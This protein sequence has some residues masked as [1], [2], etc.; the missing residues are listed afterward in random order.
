M[1]SPIVQGVIGGLAAGAATGLG[2]VMVYSLRRLSARGHDLLLSVA[3]GIMLAA[4]FYALLDPA[5]AV[6]RTRAASPWSAAA[7]VC[8]GVA[9]GVV[10]LWVL[11]R[12]VPHE[13]F[14]QGR[15]GPEAETVRRIWLFVFAITLHNLPEGM[16]VG[17]GFASGEVSAGLPLAIGIGLQNVP[18]GLAVA[19][20]LVSIGYR[21]TTAFLV[22]LGTGVLEALG[23]A[24]G[25]AAAALAESLLSWTLAF[26]GGAM[27]FVIVGEIVPE[28]RRTQAHGGTTIAFLG[29]FLLM[30]A[31]HVGLG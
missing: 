31:L 29:G 7:V 13:H 27:L 3:G 26:A 17:V 14:V 19:A 25:A 5:I 28:T 11:H 1:N 20:G 9:I 6:A 23:A 24:F 22:S 12:S 10:T 8:G 21:R 4:T 30:T 18:E 2:A 16:A 15:E